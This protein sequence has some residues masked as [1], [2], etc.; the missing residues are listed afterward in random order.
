MKK[1]PFCAEQIQDE[2]IKCRYCGSMLQD[3][4]GGPAGLSSTLNAVIFWV[5]LIVVA[6]AVWHFAGRAAS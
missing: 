4:A 5:I 6:I 1:C 2:A 3:A